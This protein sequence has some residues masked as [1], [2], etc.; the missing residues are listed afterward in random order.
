MLNW[1][2]RYR[3]TELR[4][5]HVSS[6]C[7]VFKAVDEHI[8]DKE[9]SLPLK[10]AVKLVRKK[11]PFLR[12]LKARDRNFS[13]EFVVNVLSTNMEM[14]KGG[15]EENRSSDVLM[16]LERTSPSESIKSMLDTIEGGEGG[17]RGGGGGGG[18]GSNEYINKYAS[19]EHLPEDV[20]VT[21]TITQL[22][23][24]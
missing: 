24:I 8:I 17:G 23:R 12:E 20:E 7:Y 3:P 19:L 18:S 10:V 13:D 5:E 14:T 21:N 15:V 6:T 22:R 4:P 1:H 16:M 9:T 11:T 2:G